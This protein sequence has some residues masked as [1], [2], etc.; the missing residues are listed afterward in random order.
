M[1]MLL[2]TLVSVNRF[3]VKEISKNR[4]KQLPHIAIFVGFTPLMKSAIIGNEEITRVL[5]ENGANVNALNNDGDSAL[6]LAMKN[7]KNKFV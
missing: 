2:V 5:I 4:D 7:C 6:N 3:K 1:S